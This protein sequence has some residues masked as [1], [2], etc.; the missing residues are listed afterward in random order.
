MKPDKRFRGMRKGRRAAVFKT[1]KKVKD[2]EEARKDI[3]RRK[4]QK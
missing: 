4:S 2:C 1:S 3:E